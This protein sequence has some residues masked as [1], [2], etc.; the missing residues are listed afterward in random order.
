MKRSATPHT[1]LLTQL[2]SH[3]E[4]KVL[5]FLWNSLFQWKGSVVS[6]VIP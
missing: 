6:H 1:N 3:T 2:Q 5:Y 4:S